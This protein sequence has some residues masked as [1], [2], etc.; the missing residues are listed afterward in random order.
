MMDQ[1]LNLTSPAPAAEDDVFLFPVS[2]AQQRL[3]LLD[4]LQPG[5]TA[6]N[7]P[8]AVRFGRPLDRAALQAAVDDVVRR[9]ETL[10]TNVLV[11]DGEPRQVIAASRPVI[12]SVRDLREV[13]RDALD[14]YVERLTSSEAQRPFDLS[15]DPLLRITLLSVG[16]HDIVLLTVH[17]IVADGWSMGILVRELG[18]AYAAHLQGQTPVWPELP[19]QYADYAQWQ[20]E[21]LTGAVLERQL[22]YWRTRL[23]GLPP[24]LNLPADHPRP[25]VQTYRGATR[26][27]TVSRGVTDRVE[28]LGRVEGTTLFMTLLA[29]F[30]VL[31]FRYS[32][33]GDLAVGCPIANRGR[34]E[35]EPLIGFFVNTLVMRSRMHAA[36]SFRDLLQQVKATALE[37]FDHQDL[38]FERIVEELQPERDLSHS[39]LFQAMFVLQNVPAAPLTVADVDVQTIAVESGSAKVDLTLSFTETPHGLLGAVEYSTDLFE[40]STIARMSQHYLALLE[41]ALT[42][43]SRAIGD[44]EWADQP[45]GDAS[46]RKQFAVSERLD[47]RFARQAAQTPDAI[48]VCMDDSRLTYAELDARANRLASYLRR[49]LGVD[50]E[51]RVGL[52][53]ERSVDLVVA[54]LG[55]LKAGAAYVPVDPASPAD[56]VAF[57]TADAGVVAVLTQSALE[58]RLPSLAVPVVAIDAVADVLGDVLGDEPAVPLHDSGHVAM[59]AYVIYTSGSTGRPKGVIVQHDHVQRLFLSTDPWF[60]FGSDDVWTLFHSYGFDFSVWEIWGALLYGGRLV[61]VPYLVSRSPDAF[62]ELLARERVTVLNQTPSAFGQL[63]TADGKR[64][65]ADGLALR[66]VIFGGE[67]LDLETLRPWFARHGDERPRL[68]NMYGI[69]E[70][71]VHVTFRLLTSADVEHRLGSVIGG[72]IP[73]L[74]AY[75]CDSEMRLVPPGVPG[76]LYV[77]GGGVARGYLNRPDLT[78]ERFVPDPFSKRPGERLYRSGDRARWR[79]DGDLEYLGRLDDQVKIRGFRIEPGEIESAL[80]SHEGVTSAVVIARRDGEIDPRLVAYVVTRESAPPDRAELRR[81][82]QQRLPDY[83]V[84]AAIVPIAALPL[85][86]HGKIDRAALPAPDMQEARAGVAPPRSPLEELLANIWI[87][88][89]NVPQVGRH[90]NFFELGGHSLLATQAVSRIYEV[91]GESLPLRVLFERPTIAQL[92]EA[93]E[94]MRLTDRVGAPPPLAPVPRQ[95]PLPLSF[96][97]QRLWF[98]DRI[99]VGT[100]TYNMPAA[101][102]MTGPLDAAA[103]ERSL[104]E[105]VRRH[106][107]LRTSF[108]LVDGTPIQAIHEEPRV[109]FRVVDVTGLSPAAQAEEVRRQ[110][111]EEAL[112]VFDLA[113]GPLIRGRLLRV[114]DDAHVLLM[115]LHHIVC[116]AL[117]LWILI[118]EVVEFYDAFSTDRA[119]RLEPLPVQYADFAAWQRTWLSGAVLEGQLAYWKQQLSGIPTLL[120]LPTDRPRPATQTFRGASEGFA[121]GPDLTTRLKT[122]SARAGATLFMTLLSGFAALLSRY[123]GETDVVV[124][125][126]IANR[127][128][129]ETEALVGFFVNTLALRVDLSGRPSFR[130]VVERVRQAALDAYVHQD[131][132]FEQLVEALQPER[133]LSHTPLFQVMFSWQD[134]S[135]ETIDVTGVTLTPIDPHYVAAKFDLTLGM[136]ESAAGLTG[137]LEYNVDLFDADTIV[138]M[139]RHLKTLLEALVDDPDIELDRVPLLAAAERHELLT[140]WNAR[141]K[142]CPTE[143]RVHELVADRAAERPGAIAVVSMAERLTYAELDERATRIAGQLRA[144]GVGPDVPVAVCMERSP[145]LIV[146]LLGVLK[147]GG[148]YIP[149]DPSHP[150]ARLASMIRDSGCRLVL[151]DEDDGLQ[152]PDGESQVLRVP[153]SGAIVERPASPAGDAGTP[154]RDASVGVPVG[155]PDNLAY[156]VY[157]SGS[158][159]APKGVAVSHAALLNLVHWHVRAFALTQA[160]RTTHCAGLGFDATVWETWPCLVAGAELHL[161]DRETLLS[162]QAL[163]DW[164]CD[165]RITVSFLP[166]PL[167][168]QTL[169]LDWSAASLRLLLTGGDRLHRHPSAPLPFTLVNNYG[170]SESAVVATS[171]PVPAVDAADPTLPS[172]GIGIDNVRTYVLDGRLDVVPIGVQGELHLGGLSLARGYHGDP[173]LTADR[174]V[175]DPFSEIPG[176]RLYRTGDLVRYRRDGTLGFLGRVDRQIKVRGSRIELGDVEAACLR[177]PGVT[178][179]CV[180]V[181]ADRGDES[182]LTAYVVIAADVVTDEAALRAH[183]RAQLPDHMVP[184]TVV[185]LGALPLTPNGKVDVR[186]LPNP[187][188]PGAGEKAQPE[189]DA[190]QKVASVWRDVLDR[191]GVGLHDNFF[192]VGGHSLRLVHLQQR[193]QEMFA[194]EV[195]IV[196]LFRH[197]TVHAMARHLTTP[198]T[199]GVLQ[200]A[201]ERGAR[202][203]AAM[204]RSV[205]RV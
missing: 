59:A 193:L 36:M 89:L 129:R 159:G 181:R 95:G 101:V 40:A 21:W 124:G 141:E 171:G 185:F 169:P 80:L 61:V 10:R 149:L 137:S 158:T 18:E 27:F 22:T 34:R 13:D 142:P 23:A 100:P 153:R 44:L 117:G 49:R 155:T 50:G 41:A 168:E 6:Y 157:T 103:F 161:V 112:Q 71:T 136:N 84:P 94:E 58:S 7:I 77:A 15:R 65:A 165:R 93:L 47:E 173:S 116:D 48:A 118:H 42:Q 108:P 90:D 78:A 9:H 176:G 156:I 199:E 204:R 111:V 195:R 127:T 19:I 151:T 175:P 75:L 87:D 164:F 104:I 152:L 2:F 192:E 28:A 3:W 16:D 170:P 11:I 66:W 203:R 144:N 79:S 54:I 55:V 190:E 143:R 17:H 178:D 32:R 123:T 140:D 63:V 99:Q 131:V 126:P 196:D 186:A 114:G 20:R 96:S 29:A 4:R 72:P 53:L 166:T 121:F 62:H 148:A 200:E 30:Q 120:A 56:R 189:T 154:S 33:Q 202:Q 133:H 45:V 115:T 5:N 52:F 76:E 85:T 60:C 37:A 67:A 205:R 119:P 38:P 122:F 69:T 125:S 12:V 73:D 145:A 26:S 134:A 14:G 83:M 35:V 39:P 191:D 91:L 8:A 113:T 147:A 74:S 43:P 201:E 197:P 128:R 179:A 139:S 24:I 188:G 110:G 163:R 70:T 106:E 138:R 68:V 184:A 31:L 167:A 98:L 180:V 183:L 177:H 172:I 198:E 194:R 146:A 102:R 97:Q 105:V 135:S 1:P 150:P 81:W 132:P 86:A 109:P 160:D 46:A 57:I 82:L 174:F 130:Q 107:V 64:G 92:A 187:A 88:V 162:P 182:R 25:A 51:A